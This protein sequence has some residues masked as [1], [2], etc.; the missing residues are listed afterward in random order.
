MSVEVEFS[1]PV[2]V[3]EGVAFCVR[4][5]EGHRQISRVVVAT[6]AR[7]NVDEE[8]QGLALLGAFARASGTLRSEAL[9]LVLA[10][11]SASILYLRKN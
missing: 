4:L 2:V 5:P 11:S 7:L 10:G 6:K 8:A 9:G 3:D 1:N